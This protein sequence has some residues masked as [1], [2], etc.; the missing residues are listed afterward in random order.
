MRERKQLHVL[1]ETQH[2]LKLERVEKQ[3][4]PVLS[5]IRFAA[6]FENFFAFPHFDGRDVTIAQD[7]GTA[8]LTSLPLPPE[9]FELIRI[10]L[11]GCFNT[12]A[13]E[14]GHISGSCL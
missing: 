2:H 4:E 6:I 13:F 14:L 7:L 1:T 8:E 10:F 11:I 12:I 3:L 5:Y 9:L